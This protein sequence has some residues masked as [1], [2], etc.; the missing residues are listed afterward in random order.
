MTTELCHLPLQRAFTGVPT[1]EGVYDPTPR[2]FTLSIS[3]Y[4]HNQ[5]QELNE[6]FT[7]ERKMRLFAG[8][9]VIPDSLIYPCMTPFERPDH[10]A[11][12]GSQFSRFAMCR[13][14]PIY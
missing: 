12:S 6:V 3:Q 9:R 11:P 14:L 7:D 13:D 10:L 1:K 8:L 5:Q 2:D 4:M